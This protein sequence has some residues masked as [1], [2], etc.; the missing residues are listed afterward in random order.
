[1]LCARVSEEDRKFLMGHKTNSDIY[2]SYHSAI[3]SVSVQELFR[4]VRSTNAV[5]LTGL[6]VNRLQDLPQTISLEGWQRIDQ[7]PEVIQAHLELS[8]LKAELQE[9]HGSTAVALRLGDRRAPFLAATARLKNRRLLLCHR[10]YT[11]EYRRAFTLTGRVHVPIPVPAPTLST[12]ETMTISHHHAEEPDPLLIDNETVLRDARN[13]M[14]Q[15]E[16]EEELVQELGE[17]KTIMAERPLSS[18]EDG[19]TEDDIIAEEEEER[20][21][22]T[23]PEGLPPPPLQLFEGSDTIRLHKINNG[24][25][26]PKN[27]TITRVREAMSSGGLTDAALSDLMV[28]VFS[29]THRTGKYIPGE[30]P[31]LGTAICCFSGV[32][33]SSQKTPPEVAHTAHATVLQRAAKEAFEKYLL[34]LEKQCIC[35]RY[36]PSGKYQ[37]TLC[38]FARFKT[39]REQIAHIFHHTLVNHKL[40]YAAGT[41]P[42]REWHCHLDGCVV[43]T[44]ATE[45]TPKKSQHGPKV[46]LS[47]TS[48]F[49][50]KWGYLRHLYQEHHISPTAMESVKWCGICEHFLE[51]DHCGTSIDN[52]FETHWEETWRLVAEHGY[53]GQY[54]QGRRTIPSF[55]PF[56]LH[57]EHLSPSDRISTAM[58]FLFN[59]AYKKHVAMHLDTS[60]F[61]L[62]NCPCFPKTCLYGEKMTRIDM[63]SHLSS[64]HGIER[65]KVSRAE[66]GRKVLSEKSVNIQVEVGEE[67]L[68]KRARK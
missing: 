13:W 31:L 43:L 36:G 25:A 19:V 18:Q 33:L 4:N 64:V 28:K 59:D 47:T 8:R 58:N 65:C 38:Q 32:D 68:S 62:M 20:M 54:D 66:R 10:I 26:R 45:P 46:L 57:D 2:S 22:P 23:F 40:H 6:S 34:P 42:D 49:S 9:L 55:C 61:D 53:T 39:C 30:E 52:H 37:P 16:Q 21:D 3:S 1:M 48:I 27:M 41:I 24:G 17:Y 44:T 67:K 60:G 5:E 56:C 63:A 11:E 15:V 29:A 50:S 35:Y 7:D 14:R 12:P 51:W